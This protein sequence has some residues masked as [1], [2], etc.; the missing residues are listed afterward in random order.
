MKQIDV[1]RSINSVST[2]FV[3]NSQ[4]RLLFKSVIKSVISLTTE[5]SAE[6]INYYHF[7]DL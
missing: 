3:Y 4:S 5:F 6:K 1:A 7:I 2:F